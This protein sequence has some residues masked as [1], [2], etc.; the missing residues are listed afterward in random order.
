MRRRC[1]PSGHFRRSGIP[2]HRTALIEALSDDYECCRWMAAAA[3]KEI[4]DLN[5]ISAVNT[6]L[7]NERED[8][9]GTVEELMEGS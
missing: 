7:A 1:R 9:R 5:A 6:A 4:G 2:E 8:V 3:L